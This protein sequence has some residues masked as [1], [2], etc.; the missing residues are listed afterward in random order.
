MT[1][2]QKLLGLL[3]DFELGYTDENNSIVLKE[4][5][6]NVIG[7]DGYAA[8]FIFEKNNAFDALKICKK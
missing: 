7:R 6:E 2:K 1:D 4:G 5:N 3:D 8:T